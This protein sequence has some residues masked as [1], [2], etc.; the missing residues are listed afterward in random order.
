VS[1]L[2]PVVLLVA[3]VTA[4]SPAPDTL[5]VERVLVGTAVGQFEPFDRTI[6]DAAA[7]RDLYQTR[8]PARAD[9]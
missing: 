4:C 5:R 7:V 2:A 6:T 8:S 1:R 9:R 3:V